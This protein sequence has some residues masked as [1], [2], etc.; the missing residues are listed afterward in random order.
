MK[1]RVKVVALLV[2]LA[3][4]L[5]STAATAAKPSTPAQS[6]GRY[7]VVFKAGTL[8]SDA[9]QRVVNSGGNVVRA[10]QQI[11]VV[12]AIGDAAFAKTI[13]KDA[14]VLSVGPE[15]MFAA[16]DVQAVELTDD[17]AVPE[18]AA[19]PV[20]G[21]DT[22][23]SYQWDIRRV[24]AP[25]V[26]ARLPLALTTPRVAVLDV[27]VMVDLGGVLPNHPDLAGQVDTSVA[28]SYC[29][30][31]DG[32]PVYTTYID[33]VAYPTWTPSDGCTALGANFYQAHGT[34]VAGTIAAK[35][36]GGKVV[37]VAPDAKI[38]AY[39]V[40]DAYTVDGI[41]LKIGAFDGPIFDAIIQATVAGYRVISMSLGSYGVRNNKDYN[42]SWL[43]WDRVANW[44]NRNGALIVASAG[45]TPISLNG[46]LFHIPSDLPT[47]VNTSATATS[48]LQV[49]PPGV[50]DAAPG[51]DYLAS[52]S[53]YGAAVDIAAPGGD[54]YPYVPYASCDSYPEYWILNDGIL[55]GF[56]TGQVAYYFMQGTS[57]ATPHVSAVA[58][59]VFAMHPDWTPGDVRSWLN[60]TAEVIG[61]RQQFG[62]GMVNADAATQ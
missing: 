38:G 29:A 22:Y 8:P 49:D 9:T 42:A 10:F 24:G 27:G 17:I 14:K 20:S 26:W 53:S 7:L 3:V 21:V 52:Y 35:F 28:T 60:T 37:G 45:N 5:C 16:P 23:Y 56:N 31:G 57:M 51:S 18:S 61:S 32:Y 50:Y 55:E 54:C 4:V 30:T 19:G 40:F 39:K 13:A 48:Q 59:W 36:G 44:A 2:A 12:S 58:A 15:H 1:P 6:N 62:H 34:H 25:A 43:A 11:G 41:F 46:T 33:F 47:V